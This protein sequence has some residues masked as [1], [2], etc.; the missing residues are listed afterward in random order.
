MSTLLRIPLLCLL[1]FGHGAT[2]LVADDWT[3]WSG[4][5]RK[6]NWTEDGVLKKFPEGSLKPKWVVP[7][8]SGY[9]GPVVAKGLVYVLDYVPKKETKILEAI[10]RIQCLNENTG[11]VVWDHKWETHYRRQMQSY[12]TGPRA[13]PLVDDGRVFL[14][15]A[16]GRILCLDATSG[17]V[18]WQYDALEDFGAQVPIFGFSAGPIVWKQS[19]IFACGGK[20]G[21]LIAFD[22]ASGQQLWQSLPATHDL[23]YS[24]AELFEING[25][26]QLVQW[27]KEAL[28]GMTP[29]T[30]DVLWRV[31]FSVKSNMAIGRPVQ[32][33][34]QL[35]VSGFYDGSMLVD[36]AGGEAKIVWKNGGKGE[37][38]NQ[39]ASLHA[40]IT[41]PVVEGDHFYGTC[42]YGELRGL[43]LSDGERVWENNE[44]TRQGR[45]GSMFCVKN[46]DRYFV[47]NDLGD[48]MIMQF[49]PEGPNVIDRTH[50]IDPDTE[51]GYG[52][53]KFENDLVNWVHPAY[54]N[55][56]IIIRNDH[57][58]RRISLAAP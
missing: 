32:I 2:S 53:R 29:D 57:E 17:S 41:T 54:A 19:V 56:H 55:R 3:Q 21:M 40:V 13:C 4:N 48:L 20:K 33:G 46:E 42:S 14:I 38:P 30:G 31:P 26:T 23:P 27:S 15:G 28:T 58:I 49:T 36:L 11:D 1:L 12:A 34:N 50:I 37:R 51:C 47:N 7:I 9:S 16:T 25:K 10:E 35:L 18:Q 6:G 5:D 8:G 43:T 45:W 24:S 39:T 52:P 44:L 22:K